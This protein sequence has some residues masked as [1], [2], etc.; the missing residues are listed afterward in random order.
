MPL[1]TTHFA[2]THAAAADRL[3]AGRSSVRVLAAMSPQQPDDLI[4]AVLTAARRRGIEL[5]LMFADLAGGFGFLDEAAAGD[6]ADGRLRLVSLAGAIN[7]RWSKSTDYLPYGLWDVDRM[8]ASGAIPVDVVLA[9]MSAENASGD[10]CYGE[11]VGYTETALSTSAVA[12]FELQPA[13]RPGFPGTMAVPLRRADVVVQAVNTNK[14][15][16]LSVVSTEQNE[17]GRLVGTLAPDAATLQLGLGSI[18]EA[19]LP[20][21]RG[22]RDLGLHS[23]IFT[24]SL[25]ALIRDGAINGRAKSQDAG[26][27]VATG[28]FGAGQ[29]GAEDWGSQVALRPLSATHDPRNLL[30]QDR[31][32]AINSAVEVDISGQFNVEY[33]DGVRIASAG[34]LN[35]FARAG[36][37]SK[38]GASVI[39]LPARTRQ[40]R[41]RIVPRLSS[42][43][44]VNLQGQ[45]V[46]FVVT[47]HGVAAL[48]GLSARQ[49]A[50]ALVAIAH[51]DDRRGLRCAFDGGDDAGAIRQLKRE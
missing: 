38:G 26:L 4:K 30:A 50:D 14:S 44:A 36:H 43:S 15:A 16:M 48:R 13:A 51:P 35:D 31:L 8:L 41:S 40:G 25:A 7:R 46:D 34:G 47:E 6:I 18:A 32:W 39:A 42:G 33:V 24:P 37:A 3:L 12:A 19:I 22:K 28:I 23:G 29:S 45:D 10:A 20:H 21:L 5:T 9:R 2:D 17:I 27:A 49:R 1:T 11:M